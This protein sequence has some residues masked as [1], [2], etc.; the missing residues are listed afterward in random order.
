MRYYIKSEQGRPV[1]VGYN[2]FRNAARRK[3]WTDAIWIS[4]GQK[5]ARC[6][7]KRN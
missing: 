6:A 2:A 4:G 1:E 7:Q 5:V 3:G